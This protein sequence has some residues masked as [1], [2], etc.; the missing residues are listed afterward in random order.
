MA[1]DKKSTPKQVEVA[2][3]AVKEEVK[4]PEA[5]KA[6]TYVAKYTIKELADAAKT[7][8]GTDKAIVIAA[9]KVAGKETYSM[10]EASKI[11]TS[12]K[13]KEVTK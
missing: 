7:A 3:E 4:L 13:T 8:F 12:F 9:L 5:P 2:K 6:P 10:D 11:V 1:T